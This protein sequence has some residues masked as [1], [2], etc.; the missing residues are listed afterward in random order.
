MIRNSIRQLVRT[1][2][3]S[4]LFLLLILA[5]GMVLTLGGSLWVMN[6]RNLEAYEQSFVTIGT[7]EQKATSFAQGEIWDPFDKE[8]QIVRRAVYGELTP[9]S[10]LEFSGADYIHK[11]E[12]RPCYGSYNPECKLDKGFSSLSVIEITPLENGV[13][14]RPVTVMISRI[15]Y[16]NM[17][18]IGQNIKICDE[19]LVNPKP[20]YKGK[21][22]VLCINEIPIRDGDGWKTEFYPVSVI[23]SRQYYPDG[24]L[25]PSE[26]EEDSLYYEVTE[27]LYR[28]EIGKRFME[29]AKSMEQFEHAI[30]VTGTNATILL[31]PF[32]DKD[33]YI[34]QGRDI[35]DHEYDIGERVCLISQEFAGNNQLTVGASLHLQLYYADYR[36][37]ASEYFDISSQAELN[38]IGEAYSV[39]E[40][41]DYTVV[42]IY[43]MAS[44]A[45]NGI[46]GLAKDEV[47]IPSKSIENSDINN[48]LSYGPMKSNTTSFQIPNGSVEEFMKQW[49]TLGYDHLEIKFYDRGYSTLKAGMDNMKKMSMALIVVGF[50]MVIFILLFFSHLFITKQV[51][52]TAIERSLGMRR[53]EC[54][55]SLL[56]G[57]LVILLLGSVLGSVMGG[58][59]SLGLSRKNVSNSYY[60]TMYSGGMVDNTTDTNTRDQEND[61][62]V[63]ILIST[64]SMS[65][66]ILLGAGISVY[67]INQNL[68]QEPM[69]LLS[70]QK[71]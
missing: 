52:R 4:I 27:E 2:L 36:S 7:V 43:D 13:P 55:G 41:S 30:P 28:E 22:Y 20:L 57:I 34:S 35:T 69:K 17:V 51:K 1:P 16:G 9:L 6:I 24:T 68:K 23:V 53:R 3:K 58:V 37:A 25:V 66:I 54:M 5:A 8:Y 26:L 46:Y 10:A 31:M 70:R 47:I 38:A 48:I 56:I 32:Y 61:I 60:S 65:L 63:V 14:N 42:G 49:G 39:F 33:A 11:P 67:K 64:L 62:P 21:T 15:L 45:D 40:D 71:E 12:K 44:G 50:V 18:R 19:T 59:F 29:Y